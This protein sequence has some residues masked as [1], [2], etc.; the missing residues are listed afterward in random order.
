MKP[1]RAMP[2]C[3]ILLLPV[4]FIFRTG[5]TLWSWGDVDGMEPI[6]QSWT[7]LT[8]GRAPT[9]YRP[10]TLPPPT[11]SSHTTPMRWETDIPL[12]TNTERETAP[13][14]HPPLAR[15]PGMRIPNRGAKKSSSYVY[16]SSA[17]RPRV[18][19]CWPTAPGVCWAW[20]V[21]ERSL[22][23]HKRTGWR[24]L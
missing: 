17:S 4:I 19:R 21:C 11:P 3:R 10:I 14:P 8:T 24:Q 12:I 22:L 9:E 2:M 18:T 1:D 23:I 5:M 6:A 7:G 13:A 20:R 16:Q 15:P